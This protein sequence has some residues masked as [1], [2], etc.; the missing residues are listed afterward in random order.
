VRRSGRK[1]AARAFDAMIAAVALENDPPVHTCNPA[2]FAGIDG[3]QVV[4]VP[5]PGNA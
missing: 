2:D 3:L 1:S 4:A 5:H